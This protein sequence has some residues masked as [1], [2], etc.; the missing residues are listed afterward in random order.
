[1]IEEYQRIL[2][3]VNSAEKWGNRIRKRRR[4]GEEF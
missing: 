4:E 2:L 1:M 3:Q